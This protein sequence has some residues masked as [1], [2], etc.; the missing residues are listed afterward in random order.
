SQGRRGQGRAWHVQ[1]CGGAGASVRR[2]PTASVPLVDH[3]GVIKACYRKKWVIHID[4]LN[5]DKEN[6]QT[7]PV[8]VDPSKV[9]RAAAPQATLADGAPGRSSSPSSR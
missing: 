6:G 7:V 1:G 4:K 5:R 8:G 2:A 3:T 9:R